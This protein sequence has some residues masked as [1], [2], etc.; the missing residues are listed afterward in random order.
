MTDIVIAGNAGAGAVVAWD[1]NSGAALPDYLKNALEETGS[2]IQDRMSVPS[3]SYEGKVWQI[4]K[5]SNRQKLQMQNSDGDIVPV[6][7]MRAVVLNY[8]GDRG[9]AYYEGTY[10]PSAVTAPKCWSA[11]GKAPDDSVK[12]KMSALCQ[13]CPMS[14]KGSKVDQGRE[15]VACSSHRM[16][17]VAPAF[18]LDDE[19]LRLK[20][21][22]TSDYDK[23]L[24]DHGWFAF[25]QYVDFLKSKGISHTA[26][27]VTKIKFDQ[28]QA[29]PKLLFAIDR[30]LTAEEVQKVIPL[31]KSDAVRDLLVEK[32]TAAGVNG[33]DKTDSDIKPHGL[34]G[35]YLDGWQAHPDAAGYSWKGQEVITN[36]ELAAR[37]PAPVAPPAP[38]AQ[39]QAAPAAPTAPAVPAAEQVIEH[40]PQQ[41]AAA[42]AA[43]AKE[44]LVAATS[45]PKP[46]DPA[47]IAHAGTEHE[48]WWNG[49]EWAKPWNTAPMHPT[50]PPAPPAPPAA[51]AAPAAPAKT[52]RELALEAGWVQH[53]D[54]APHGYLGSEVL[55]WPT[56]EARYAGNGSAQ[57][58][59]AAAGDQ[60]S[61]AGAS[62]TTTT[63]T[64]AASPSDVPPEVAELLGKWGGGV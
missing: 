29:Y 21:A 63:A 5:N 16:L 48:L 4:V 27:V 26:M 36:E 9:R 3:L 10:N 6:P 55:D 11:D 59:T 7:V 18:N 35:A 44:Q 25:R 39:E 51:P 50:E 38:P 14:V 24:V 28:N 54:S 43:P 31:T 61:A 12:E 19:P 56:I 62:S 32:W 47:H 42:P 64:T 33:T 15:M 40:A 34:E 37:Y 57:T 60:G 13:G 20:I 8:N 17:A 1:P 41:Q 22:V 53:P 58:A 46:T 30:V 2:N 52:P 49:T 23:E 45:A